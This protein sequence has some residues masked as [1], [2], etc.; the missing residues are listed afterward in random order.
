MRAKVKVV[1]A[2]A[3]TV[4][5]TTASVVAAPGVAH[6]DHNDPGPLICWFQVTGSSN[7]TWF[8][9]HN[10]GSG[11]A[12]RMS[13]GTEFTAYRDTE[14]INQT[15]WR[16]R[17]SRSDPIWANAGRMSGPIGSCFS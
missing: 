10:V 8:L 11:V 16:P 9:N 1:A 4:I 6:A 13:P 17:G 2:L 5:A 12:D 3:A 15:T 7:L 14:R